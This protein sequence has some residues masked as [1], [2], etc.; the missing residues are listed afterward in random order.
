ME[1]PISPDGLSGPRLSSMVNEMQAASE[2]AEKFRRHVSR[3]PP[4][5]RQQRSAPGSRR[6]HRPSATVTAPPAAPP[7]GPPAYQPRPAYKPRPPPSQAAASG[8][9]GPLAAG[10]WGKGPREKRVTARHTS[11]SLCVKADSLR[12]STEEKVTDE[13]SSAV[14]AGF[15][16]SVLKKWM[17]RC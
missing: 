17:K 9:Q 7:S 12:R 2:E 16:A 13:T 1:C 15:P 8:Q 11:L 10:S 4:P 3:P 6:R 14:P 5:P